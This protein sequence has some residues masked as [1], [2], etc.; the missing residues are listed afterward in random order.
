[1]MMFWEESGPVPWMVPMMLEVSC[2]CHGLSQARCTLKFGVVR[3]ADWSRAASPRVIQNRGMLMGRRRNFSSPSPRWIWSGSTKM[4][5][6]APSRAAFC[7][8]MPQ[9]KSSRTMLP[10]TG[11]PRKARRSPRPA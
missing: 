4:M 2:V 8:S 3:A 5:A 6:L 7:Q 11:L 9:L 1:M 10:S